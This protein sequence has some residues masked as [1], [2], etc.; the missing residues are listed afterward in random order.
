[1]SR[2]QSSLHPSRYGK[3]P[4]TIRRE[5]GSSKLIAVAEADP[6]EIVEAAEGATLELLQDRPVEFFVGLSRV[7]VEAWFIWTTFLLKIDADFLLGWSTSRLGGW[8]IGWIGSRLGG[9]L[10]C[11]LI[12]IV[13]KHK[14]ISKWS[15]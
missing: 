5:L 9:W 3:H 10:G 13:E 7:L 8:L 11:V 15:I 1:M 6:L 12:V 4:L 14:E 2:S